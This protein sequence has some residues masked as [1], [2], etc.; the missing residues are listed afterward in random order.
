MHDLW[1]SASYEAH[2]LSLPFALAPAAMLIVIAYTAVMRGAPALRG[3]LLAHCLSLLPYAVVM[4][5][6]PSIVEGSVAL[7]LFQAAASFIP[8]AAICGTAFQLTLIRKYRRFRVLIWIGVASAAAWIVVSSTTALAVSGVRRLDAGLWYA[9]AGSGAWIALVHTV[10]LSI[11][12][13]LALGWVALRSRPS[14]E[15]RQL[16]LALLANIVTYA[17]LIDVGLAYGIGVFP[18]G[19][20]LS[21]IGSLLV[22]R[23][24]IVE[25]LLRVRAVDN[26]APLLVVHVAAGILL[27]WVVLEQ[28]GRD[29]PW[30][31]LTVGLC[32]CFGAVRA[33][34]ATVDLVGRNARGGE[35]PLERLQAQLVA[36]ARTMTEAPLIAQLAIDIVEL[37]IGV[38]ASIL[39]ASAE[40]WGWTTETGAR[41]DD[42]LAPDPLL[43]SWLAERRSTV[44]A[45]DLDPVPADL[46]EL[47]ST[48]F[49]R[50]DARAI[51]PVGSA[52][53]L[54]GLVIL[55]VEPRKLRGRTLAFLERT[56][57][58]LAEALLHARMAQRAA[59]RASLAREVELAA[60]VQGELLP[61]KGPHV[62]GEFTVIG[63]WQPATRCAGDFWGVY[64]LGA[65][66]EG[67]VLIAIGDVTGHGVASAM[68]TAAA[69]G[70]VD[71]CVRRSGADL[72]L[73]ELTAA[74][75]AAVRRVG[76][77]ELAMTCFAA[78]LD[79]PAREVRFVSCGHT[80]P[81]LCRASDKGVELQALV[82]RG[83]PLGAGVPAAPKLLH[84]P[85][86][87]GDLLVWYT[88]GVIEAQDPAGTPF[89][90]RKLQHLLRRLD[91]NRVTP[92]AV[93]DVVQASVAAHRAG[94]PLADDETVVV[95]Q[96]AREATP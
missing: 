67:R 4:M 46:R 61:G 89:G 57:E 6:S 58:R 88:D 28:L 71:V 15:R 11:G 17:G 42:E 78:I 65:A 43:M 9:N 23:A 48:L 76:G 18:L 81:Y 51:V 73:R 24:L 1:S 10:V 38:R 68:V 82:G 44:F 62:H 31:L 3:W 96:L 2:L 66:S 74:L 41:V 90:D 80:S 32:I 8:M 91:K 14:D 30:W 22:V 33:S 86:A 84:R 37:G 52:D 49:E 34:V 59:E 5:L 27:G 64:P 40:D 25:D 12:G 20:L 63:S 79:A 47:L 70:A 13:F 95:A 55:A 83:N 29:L 60:T 45:D 75:D 21:G 16:R 94:H 39:L 50:H 92:A 69:V 85:I 93:H 53:E 7:V 54:I 87:P 26:R 77:G 36:R 19:W 56:A 72:D 35:G